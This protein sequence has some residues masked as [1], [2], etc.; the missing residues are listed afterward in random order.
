M[1]VGSEMHGGYLQKRTFAR[2]ELERAMADATPRNA[3]Q[4]MMLYHAL[5]QVLWMDRTR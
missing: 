4:G 3:R 1:N 2:R 5:S